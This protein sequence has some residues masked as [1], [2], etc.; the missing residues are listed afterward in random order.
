MCHIRARLPVASVQSDRKRNFGLA[1]TNGRPSLGTANS[2]CKRDEDGLAAAEL[3][4]RRAPIYIGRH[5]GPPYFSGGAGSRS[6]QSSRFEWERDSK[7]S[8]FF[9]Y[10]LSALS[11]FSFT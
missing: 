8:A 7:L 5:G 10:K 6:S 2:H 4:R 1:L 3:S 11:L 9:N